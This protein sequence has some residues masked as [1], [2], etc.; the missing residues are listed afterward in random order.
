LQ[1]FDCTVQPVK[2]SSYTKSILLHIGFYRGCFL[3]N[4]CT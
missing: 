2:F 4:R 3:E 1:T